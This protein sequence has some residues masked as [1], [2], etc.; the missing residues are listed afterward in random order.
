MVATGGSQAATLAAAVPGA[1]MVGDGAAPVVG[2]AYDSRRVEPGFLFAALPGGY[3]DGHD[4]VVAAV[5]RGAT[6]LLVERVLPVATTQLVV[7]DSRAALATVAAAY[8]RHPSREVGVI[9]ITGTDGK[10]TVSFLVDAILRGAGFATGLIG[11]VAIRVGAEEDIHTTRQTTPESADIQRLLR[12]M[13]DR[14]IPWATLEAT[15]HGLAMHRLDGTRFRVGA[16]TN[17]TSEHLDY[18]GTVENYRRVKGSLFERV[19]EAGGIA[20]IN[21]DDPGARSMVEFAGNGDILTYS[22]TSESADIRAVD[23]VSTGEGSRF[24]LDGGGRGGVVVALPLIGGFNVANALCAAGVGIAL[25]LKPEVIAAGLNDA[26]AVPGRMALVREGQPFAVVVDYAHTPEALA[27]VLPLLRGLFPGGR[28]IVVFG[29]A[30]ERDREKRP[31]QGE[32]VARLADIAVVT[33]EDPRYEDP[34][35]IIDEIARGALGGGAV[36][37]SSL[38]RV[39]DRR[40]AVRL[41]LGLANRGDCVLLAGKGHE[42]SIIWGGEKHPWDEAGVARS[43]LRDLGYDSDR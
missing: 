5:E 37:G 34:D 33:S 32:V 16:V 41:A 13:A 30:G 19:A 28:L 20:V 24:L 35:A 15:S 38:F 39:T 17:V 12:R 3:A 2:I 9:G 6:A 23:V 31:R 21:R 22:V 10:T 26:P 4:F 18:H 1:R 14:S 43:L 7:P 27:K 11:T 8:Y 42:G 29:S 36:E 40:E 25:G